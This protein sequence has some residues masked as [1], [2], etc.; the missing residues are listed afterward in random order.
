MKVRVTQIKSG[1]G[2]PLRQKQTLKSLGLRRMHQS[3]E[4][5][6]NPQIQGM[7]D[8]VSHLIKVE[9]IN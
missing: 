7:I 1:I 6:L 2:Y 3:K 4:H 8:K 9:E 5:E